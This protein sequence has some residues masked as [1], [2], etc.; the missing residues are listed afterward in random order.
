LRQAPPPVSPSTLAS[1]PHLI[2][3]TDGD[4]SL[5]SR[6]RGRPL[7]SGVSRLLAAW[8]ILG[9]MIAIAWAAMAVAAAPSL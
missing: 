1:S 3:V 8:A 6:W 4:L 9:G 7:V 5:A 2:P